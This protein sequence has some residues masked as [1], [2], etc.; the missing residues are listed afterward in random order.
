MQPPKV[1]RIDCL[2][3]NCP[4]WFRRPD[5]QAFLSHAGQFGEGWGLA[6]WHE[7]GAEPG[8][9]SDIFMTF[10]HGVGSDYHAVP[11][12]VWEEICQAAKAHGVE[13]GV[14]W[15]TNLETEEDDR[16]RAS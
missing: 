4:R 12:D 16:G 2:R 14:I 15:V 6:T 10:D 9:C 8:E 1:E 5:F 13:Y 3:L 7:P 11:E